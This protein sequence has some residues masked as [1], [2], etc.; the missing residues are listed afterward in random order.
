ML[1]GKHYILL[2]TGGALSA[3]SFWHIS[4][5]KSNIYGQNSSV[6]P[7][8]PGKISPIEREKIAVYKTTGSAAPIAFN[9]GSGGKR[10]P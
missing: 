5:P 3:L 7:A 10:T 4:L 8:S 9:A 6:P 1:K 2:S